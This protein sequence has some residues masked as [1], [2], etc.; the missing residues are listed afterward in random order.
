MKNL[1]IIKKFY[2]VTIIS[3][4]FASNAFASEK[5]KLCSIEYPPIFQS[6]L[7]PGLGYGVASDITVEA[8]KSVNV[9]VSFDFIPMV[10]SVEYVIQ[11]K[12]PAILGTISWFIRDKK[13]HLVQS[14][15]LF[16]IHFLLFYKKSKFPEGITYDNLNELSKY[17]I[18]NV[19]GSSTTPIVEKA[20]LTIE[21]VSK[22]ELNFKKL[23]AGRLDFAI[24][25]G[26]SGWGI[27]RDL[28]PDSIND[29]SAI[30]KPIFTIPISLVFSK[31]QSILKEKF[32]KGIDII[33]ENG[34]FYEIME[35]YYGKDKV[36]D[37]ILPQY[38]RDKINKKIS[39]IE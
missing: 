27:L 18:G 16:T 22:L 24:G 34:K 5:Y 30:K 4:L 13:D 33:L 39:T 32:Q 31:N 23:H 7:L 6:K 2:L 35:R 28:Y 25:A 1:Q 38:V 10:R 20:N 37:N 19:R 26:I 9:D 3:M 11:E 15:D 21:W 17:N 36:S 14:V 12:Y 29:F 8:F